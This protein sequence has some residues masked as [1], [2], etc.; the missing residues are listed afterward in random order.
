MLP[1]L[2]ERPRWRIFERRTNI[3]LGLSRAIPNARSLG[4]YMTS[5]HA[6][7]IVNYVDVQRLAASGAFYTARRANTPT[8]CAPTHTVHYDAWCAGIGHGVTGAG[9]VAF[10]EALFHY[11]HVRLNTSVVSH[12]HL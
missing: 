11:C 4:M 7:P 3:T 2:A 9:G 10:L 8:S 5:G 12:S 6:P 1:L